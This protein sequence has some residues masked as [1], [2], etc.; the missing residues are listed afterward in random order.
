MFAAIVQPQSP[1]HRIGRGVSPAVTAHRPT[2]LETSP[3]LTTPFTTDASSPRPVVTL[4]PSAA[5]S[6]AASEATSAATNTAT[7]DIQGIAIAEVDEG[8]DAAH[9]DLKLQQIAPDLP[10]DL[11]PDLP[12]DLAAEALSESRRSLSLEQLEHL[13]YGDSA[14]WDTFVADW[15]PR[16]F[17]YL[18]Y[19]LPTRE[20]AEDALSETLVA[21]VEAIKHFDGK[22]QVSTWLYSIARRKVA[23]FWRKSSNTEELSDLFQDTPNGF[24]LEFR[25]ALAALPEQSRQALLLRYREGFSVSEVSEI[26]GRTYKATESLLSRG[27]ALLARQLQPEAE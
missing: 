6:A 17:S 11:P 12:P 21:T 26:M 18:R 22:S 5:D 16:L 10:S 15:S 25:E 7:L 4:Y 9:A 27:R 19:S 23:D 1:T 13:R 24:S 8:L 14:A 20:D 3:S 2:P